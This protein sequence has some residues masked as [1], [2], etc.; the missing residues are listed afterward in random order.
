MTVTD[1]DYET[2]SALSRQMYARATEVMPGGNSRTAVFTAP[3][4]I[5]AR[6][7]HGCR[8][9]D[10]DGVERTDFLGNSTTLL[11]GHAH[12][13]VVAAVI[14]AVG[15]G[16][17][18]GLPT[19]TEVEFAELL[20]ARSD[21]FEH[22]RFTSTGT[23]AVMMAVQAARAYTGRSR[24]AKLAGAYHGP[25]DAV[26]VNNDGTDSLINH[27]RSGGVSATALAETVVIPFNDPEGAVEVLHRHADA[28]A[29][30]LIDPMPWRTG[31]V[32][33]TPEYLAALRAF[34]DETGV[35]LVSD[36]VGSFRIGYHGAIDALGGA[37]DLTVLGKIIGAGLPIGAVAGRR[38]VMAVFDPRGGS[39]ALPHSGSYNANPV[40]MSAGIASLNLWSPE[41]F[42]RL[43]VLGGAARDAMRH[44]IA[45]AGLDWQV[46]GR[47]S[48]F[49]VLVGPV[50]GSSA[51]T[52]QINLLLYRALLRHGVL[53]GET[54]LGCVSTPMGSAEV[55]Q[56]RT[57]FERAV[58]DV[59]TDARD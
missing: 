21:A 10:L 29:C 58:H 40:S 30:V 17:S 1:T 34:C 12:P 18:F 22:V 2:A 8:V 37:A 4:P 39:P 32:A 51:S 14:D 11:H 27:S 59:V 48:L 47:E 38:E 41:E 26:A 13:A 36:E 43:G 53:V 25:Y 7:G 33:A 16:A 50:P 57:A 24:V 35:P 55:E 31:L 52:A 44:V 49:R 3:Y 6:S 5:Y 20:A 56:L 9:V 46:N 19:A 45:E 54:G 28:L 23:E 15:R 42:R